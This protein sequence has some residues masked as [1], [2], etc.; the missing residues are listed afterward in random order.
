MRRVVIPELLDEDAG[1]PHEIRASLDDLRR[2][3][4]WFGGASTTRDMITR[5]LSRIGS[6]K[7]SLLDVGAGSGDVVLAAQRE[8]A[9]RGV[10]L[11]LT[12]LDRRASHLPCTQAALLEHHDHTRNDC[13]NSLR[14]VAG[15]AFALPFRTGAFDLVACSLLVHHFEPDE[16]VQ[17][18]NEALRVAS[19]A[20]L[21]NDLRRSALSLA[22]VYC[23]FPLFRS[24]LTRHDAPAS[25]RR[26]YTINEMHTL[27]EKTTAHHVEVTP[28]YLFRMAAIAWH[29]PRCAWCKR[30]GN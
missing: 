29:T 24:A 1:P 19:V 16:V 10:R 25:V 14:R 11:E 12:L 30:T 23:G 13:G 9:R 18:V 4:S 21:I 7:V 20:V 17:F 22:L 27:L 2:V 15:D 8:L 6:N 28:H 5:V 3:N 26:A